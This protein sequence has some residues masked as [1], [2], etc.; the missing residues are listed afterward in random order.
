VG[1]NYETN[2]QEYGR[3]TP[4]PAGNTVNRDVLRILRFGYLAILFVGVAALGSVYAVHNT[5]SHHWGFILGA[6][7]D[8]IAGRDLFTEVY[9]Q[10]GAAQPLLH[11]AMNYFVPLTYT[12]I[13]LLTAV[14][15]AASLV[16]IFLCVE[17]LASTLHAVLLTVLAFLH[18]PYAIFPW[19]DYFAGFCLI[20]ACYCLLPTAESETTKRDVLAGLLLFLAFLFRNT[21]V[22]NLVGA[23]GLYFVA[24]IAFPKLKDQR[25]MR[26]CAVFLLTTAAYFLLLSLQHKLMFWYQ[27]NLGAAPTAYGIGAT[28][29][30][31]LL[32]RMFSP[33]SM[34]TFAFSIAIWINIFNVVMV[35][36]RA[37]SDGIGSPVTSPFILFF[38]LLG[39]AGVIQGL[40]FYEPYRLQSACSPL[41]LGVACFLAWR[42][43]GHTTD[44]R[45]ASGWVLAAIIVGLALTA[46]SLFNGRS[47][48][49]IW[50]LIE[51]PRDFFYR[52]LEGEARKKTVYSWSTGIPVFQ[53]HRFVPDM[54]NYYASL[55]QVLCPS[56]KKIVNLTRDSMVA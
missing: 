28:T 4:V 6:S 47:H 12:N 2:I 14:T 18:H 39:L 44:L 25:I 26:A 45:P 41:Y 51:E 52:P 42:P 22:V 15:Y 43:T 24:A 9:M 10:Y 16:V 34:L 17:R 55:A 19:P 56:S 49:T 53:G 7:L 3:R 8:F 30:V 31:V 5:D 11:K 46:P 27:Q 48:S 40:Q 54:Q 50:P 20:L 21:Y 37:R 36:R 38:G 35:F 1:T 32:D 13:G 23:A 33:Y 29:G